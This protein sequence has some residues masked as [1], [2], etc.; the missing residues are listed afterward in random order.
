VW[1][2]INFHNGISNQADR[3]LLM[4]NIMSFFQPIPV[5]LMSL[6]VD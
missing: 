4:T 3:D 5:E 6:S 1:L 2:G